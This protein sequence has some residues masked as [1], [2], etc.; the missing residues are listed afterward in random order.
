MA[1]GFELGI[2]I[3]DCA[4]RCARLP[5]CVG[6][7]FESGSNRCYHASVDTPTR[8]DPHN[9]SLSVRCPLISS[10][11][12]AQLHNETW[13]YTSGQ[14]SD[15]AA[16]AARAAAA[17]EVT[18]LSV[19]TQSAE[20]NDRADLSLGVRQEALIQAVLAAAPGRVVVVVRAPGAVTM[21]W[22]ANITALP[23]IML[24]LMPGQAAGSALA[25]ILFGDIEPTGRLPVS[26]PYSMAQSWL[27]NKTSRYP[28]VND[29]VIWNGDPDARAHP[30][31]DVQAT[32]SEGLHMGYRYLL[33]SHTQ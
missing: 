6:V 5:W 31:Q 28:G 27:E 10:G 25:S 15:G 17:A 18:V 22:A 1:P 12:V 33:R 4:A 24:Q 29:S 11:Q 3:D 8:S 20:G 13:S 2:G 16:A 23:A 32:Y 30:S 26:F 19:A 21:P 14:G 7:S 9:S